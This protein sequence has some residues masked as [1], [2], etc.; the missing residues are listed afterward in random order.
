MGHL[1]QTHAVWI[2]GA[3]AHSLCQPLFQKGSAGA[4]AD[5]G[6]YPAAEYFACQRTGLLA[7]EPACHR[8]AADPGH[9]GRWFQ[10]YRAWAELSSWAVCFGP[11]PAA[12]KYD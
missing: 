11:Q 1:G 7:A 4:E 5:L 12:A 6:H 9:G 10:R 8:R 2:R 3:D